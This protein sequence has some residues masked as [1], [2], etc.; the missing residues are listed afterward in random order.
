MIIIGLIE[1]TWSTDP[2]YKY[3]NNV[4]ITDNNCTVV[5]KENIS[6]ETHIEAKAQR[7]M[8]YIIHPQLL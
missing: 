6:K 4:Q 1:I 3:C 8:I 7:T 2:K 5:M